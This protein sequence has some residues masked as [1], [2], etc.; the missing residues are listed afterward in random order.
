MNYT[1]QFIIRLLS[2]A[3]A[4]YFIVEYV[5]TCDVPTHIGI[6]FTAMIMVSVIIVYVLKHTG[7][8]KICREC[9]K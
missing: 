8:P 4:V 1:L 7:L 9:G 2:F 6:I 5:H 3:V